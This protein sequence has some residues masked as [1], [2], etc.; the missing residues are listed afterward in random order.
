M[1]NDIVMFKLTS[2]HASRSLVVHEHLSGI[3]VIS[4]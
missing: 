4:V 2:Q 3:F 1:H